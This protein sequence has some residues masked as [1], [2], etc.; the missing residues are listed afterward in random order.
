MDDG[1]NQTEL[2]SAIEKPSG[3]HSQTTALRGGGEQQKKLSVTSRVI[4]FEST[5]DGRLAGSLWGSTPRAET[6]EQFDWHFSTY[7][8]T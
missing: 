7:R 8:K 1:P 2:R 4:T 3:A 5:P 6:A